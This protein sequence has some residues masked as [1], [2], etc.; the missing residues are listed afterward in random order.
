MQQMQQM[1][2]KE[3][4]HDVLFKSYATDFQVPVALAGLTMPVY[5]KSLRAGLYVLPS[6]LK[7]EDIVRMPG[8]GDKSLDNLYDEEPEMGNPLSYVPKKELCLV[9]TPPIWGFKYD[10]VLHGVAVKVKDMIDDGDDAEMVREH[11]DEAIAA[12]RGCMP[13]DF[14][15]N[16]K[17]LQRVSLERMQ[18]ENPCAPFEVLGARLSPLTSGAA[19][20]L[21]V[22]R[23]SEGCPYKTQ[24]YLD[25][26]GVS[27][28]R[29]MRVRVIPQPIIVKNSETAFH[30]AEVRIE[31]LGGA[32]DA[33]FRGMH[34]HAEGIATMMKAKLKHQR[35]DRA[36]GKLII[37]VQ[38]LDAIDMSAET[39]KRVNGRIRGLL[40][41]HCVGA[42]E[43]GVVDV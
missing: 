28:M 42:I 12:R 16:V 2:K 32:D 29:N 22:L 14:V 41:G 39:V 6:F 17:R 31:V 11:G 5:V 3:R 23:F 24:H 7:D 25:I 20:V 34:S 13:D 43:V 10:Q 15:G 4:V 27:G 30:V 19:N 26:P 8:L 33:I 18:A 1:Q 40:K 38:S 21:I 9:I 35:T 36:T 37:Q